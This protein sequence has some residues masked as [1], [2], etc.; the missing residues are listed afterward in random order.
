MAKNIL[1]LFMSNVKTKRVAD[2][3]VIS[4]AHYENIDGENTRTTN[5]SAVRY[6]LQKKFDGNSSALDMIFIV[7]SKKVHENIP[8]YLGED[9]KAQTHLEFTT[10]RFK[11]F[12][13][14]TDF[15]IF[16]YDE[17]GTNDDNL[18][19]VAKMAQRIQNFAE[20]E[21]VALHVDLTGGMRHVNMMML[22]LTRLL[23][24]SGLSV[25]NVLYSNYN[26]YTATGKVEE[27]QNVYDLF[28]LIAGVEEFVNFG[29][30]KALKL[31]YKD[32]QL[33]EP[34][35][36][37]L[38][39]MEK[40]AAETKLCHYGQFLDAI[41]NL[42]DSVHDFDKKESENVEDVLM[43]RFIGRIRKNYH[44]LIAGRDKDDLRIIRWCLDNDYLQ[45]ALTLYTERIP[46][47][48]GE[49]KI[50][51]QSPEK[52]ARL[53]ALVDEDEMGRNTVF[54]LFSD[55]SPE[56]DRLGKTLTM[57]RRSLK[58]DA[59]P[60]IRKKRFDFVAWAE[61]LDKK[62][63]PFSIRNES[64]LRLQLETLAKIFQDHM[65]LLDLQ[66]AEL[67]PIRGLI[68][69]LSPNLEQQEK[70]FA[71]KNVIAKFM[72]DA[73]VDKLTEIFDGVRF[74]QLITKYPNARKIY[75]LLTEEAFS[76]SIDE[77]KFLS[78]MDKYFVIKHER[79]HCN[80]AH[81]EPSDFQSADE[82]RKF[83]IKAIDELK[84]VIPA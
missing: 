59:W 23:E 50:I 79:N 35:R 56:G 42:H 67:D 81:E 47:Y 30:V 80:H 21:E 32:K 76:V 7:A 77:E 26:S 18:K 40:F 52:S 10:E 72:D 41:V 38:S 19:S 1:L 37:L 33:S 55:F 4:E 16:D 43:A 24:Y 17:D 65:I 11:K 45:Q 22:E 54:Y 48:L 51:T 28:Q 29:S 64:R 66:S 39:A 61:K 60:L 13:P 15:E 68:N 53:Q 62:I 84:S 9:G 57:Y 71:R 69:E 34:L 25:D 58:V 20:D 44:E 63:A 27:I 2:K 36:N 70:C 78:I 14:E 46:E 31:Y 8:N 74:V 75:E 49:K 3:F 82:L 5:E 12:L 73:K 83:M 6:L